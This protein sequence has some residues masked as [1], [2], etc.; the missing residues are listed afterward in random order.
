MGGNL[1]A[2]GLILI[3][4]ITAFFT[5][6]FGHRPASV[7]RVLKGFASAFLISFLA[8]SLSAHFCH[9]GDPVHQWTIA[10]LCL[11]VL[12]TFVNWRRISL[13]AG[14]TVIVLTTVLA[15]Q[16][17]G[18]VHSEEYTGN[19]EWAIRGSRLEAQSK[20]KRL[21]EALLDDWADEPFSASWLSETAMAEALRKVHA[22]DLMTGQAVVVHSFWHTLLTGL[23]RKSYRSTAVWYPGGLVKDALPKLEF[24]EIRNKQR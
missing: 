6:R 1:N 20:L 14:A 23:Y 2:L 19:P 16:F 24:R 4:T 17:L 5:A 10:A 12:A 13:A 7:V 11:G 8:L 18:L 3:I 9:A 15:I 21:R 22:A